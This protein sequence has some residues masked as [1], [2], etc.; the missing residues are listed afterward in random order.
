MPP[1]ATQTRHASCVELTEAPFNEPV[2]RHLRNQAAPG[3]GDTWDLQGWE[4]HVHPDLS[5]RFA[6]V[7]PTGVA[8]TPAY[9][10]H[11]LTASGVAA[12]FVQG[13]SCLFLRLPVEPLKVAQSH[14]CAAIFAAPN[15]YAIDPW[16]SDVSTEVGLG[17]LRILTKTAHEFALTFT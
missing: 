15:W 4:L 11:V 14:D 12:G 17:T 5:D 10:V 6:Q 2:I 1:P 16:Q 7:S 3:R 8:L 9:G 13:T